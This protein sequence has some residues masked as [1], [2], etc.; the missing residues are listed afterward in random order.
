MSE[1]K[2]GTVQVVV[3]S[4]PYWNLRNYGNENPKGK[5]DLGLESTPQEFIKAMTKHLRDVRRVLSDKGS[6]FL[7]MGDTY[8]VGQNFL[9]PTRLFLE[10]CDN[11]GW[12]AV[13]EIIWKKSG[14][15][16][17]GEVKRLL[18]I[19]EKVYHLVKDPNMYYYEEFKNWKE[20][21]KI[22]IEKMIGYRSATSTKRTGVGYVLSRTFERFRDFLD[23]QTVR[24][25]INGHTAATRGI[26]LKK[27]DP[28]I[29]HPALMPV[30]LPMIPIL[31]TSRP[32][33]I[34]LDPFSGSATTGRAALILGRRYVGY[35]INQKFYDLSVQ[36]LSSVEKSLLKDVNE[37]DSNAE[38]IESSYKNKNED[39]VGFTPG[40]RKRNVVHRKGKG[41][42]K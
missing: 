18:P 15:V 20:S 8:R 34:V 31:T 37:K 40:F 2:S 10:L 36:D 28:S 14:G 4:P 17:Q 12:Y 41:T 13:N 33:D 29:D 23:E 11:E 25:V 16:P 27:L 1:V 3:T 9:I 39:E 24:N 42:K 38:V 32:G 7:N 21:D 26:E 22:T 6:F 19:Y 30:Y 35:E 5:P